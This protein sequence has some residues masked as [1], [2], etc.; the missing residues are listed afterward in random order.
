MT[1]Y[2]DTHEKC[3]CCQEIKHVMDMIRVN[4]HRMCNECSYDFGDMV[5]EQ[6]RDKEAPE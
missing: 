6:Q 2:E 1:G 4:G 3:P 5:M